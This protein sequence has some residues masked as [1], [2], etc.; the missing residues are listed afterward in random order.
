MKLNLRP[1]K[2][3]KIILGVG[4]FFICLS[5]SAEGYTTRPIALITAYLMLIFSDKIKR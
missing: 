4:L 5:L 2:K 3:Q 1:N